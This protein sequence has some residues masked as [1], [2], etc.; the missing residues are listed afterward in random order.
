MSKV[1]NF[2]Q[3]QEVNKLN[4]IEEFRK[5]LHKK[6]VRYTWLNEDDMKIKVE[7]DLVVFFYHD[8]KG[9]V[10]DSPLQ[11]EQKTFKEGDC[12]ETSEDNSQSIVKTV[13]EQLKELYYEHNDEIDP[14][15]IMVSFLRG[16]VDWI[17][18]ENNSFGGLLSLS[19]ISE[20]LDL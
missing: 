13:A 14:S 1:E 17:K 2:S 5:I 8:K 18:K 4:K 20:D 12:L 16:E 19:E 7:E 15:K 3:R 11:Q 6:P 10:Q 9:N